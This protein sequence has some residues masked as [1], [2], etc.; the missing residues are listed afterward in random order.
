MLILLVLFYFLDLEVVT[1][2]PAEVPH[3]RENVMRMT[4][5]SVFSV[6]QPIGTVSSTLSYI[7]L[8]SNQFAIGF[9]DVSSTLET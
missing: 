5:R 6:S 4:P 3:I 9:S 7:K 8:M 2:I 1:G